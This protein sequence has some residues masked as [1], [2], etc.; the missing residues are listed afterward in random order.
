M[1]TE[2]ETRRAFGLTRQNE[3]LGDGVTKE[4]INDVLL[5]S[6]NAAISCKLTS[7]NTGLSTGKKQCLHEKENVVCDLLVFRGFKDNKMEVFS[8]Y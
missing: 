3:V 4:N 1:A 8:M 5:G 7:L 6:R 2:T